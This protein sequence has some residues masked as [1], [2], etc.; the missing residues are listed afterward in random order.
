MVPSFPSRAVKQ[1]ARGQYAGG[2]GFPSAYLMC[3]IIIVL[4]ICICILLFNK[5]V[6]QNVNRIVLSSKVLGK[7]GAIS[8]LSECLQGS[9]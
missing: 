5:K 2:I 6:D 9:A 8:Q 1:A 4:R 3:L 7:Q